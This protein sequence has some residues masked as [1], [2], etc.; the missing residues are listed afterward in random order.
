M[1]KNLKLLR[2]DLGLSQKE[3]GK[4]LNVTDT[5]VSKWESGSRKL[6]KRTLTQICD[7]FNVNYEW[8]ITGEGDTY[9]SVDDLNIATMMGKVFADNDEFMKNVFLT[10][11]KLTDSERTVLMKVIGILNELNNK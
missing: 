11:S 2:E 6:N 1:N 5:T 7:T 9:K 8:L 4:K 3:F 10:F